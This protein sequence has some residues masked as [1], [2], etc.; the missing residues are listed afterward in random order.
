M[1]PSTEVT[2]LDRSEVV[3]WL[4]LVLLVSVVLGGVL[5]H[6]FYGLGQWREQGIHLWWTTYFS[7]LYT[8][9][10]SG[11]LILAGRWLRARVP[12]RSR[13]AVILHVGALSVVAVA[14]YGAVTGLC[15]LL[16]PSVFSVDGDTMLVTAS[17]AFL[18][19][20]L[21][22]AFAYMSRF[23]R[24]L[25]KAEAARYEAQLEAL[26]AQINPHFLFNAF[27]SIAALIRARP[28][29]AEAVVENLADLFR[30]TLWA[31][32]RNT[33]T[34]QKE[35][36]AARR[37]LAVEEA[38]FRD[39]LAVEI[40]VPETLQSASIPSMT[41]QPLVENAVK[42]GVGETNEACTVTI[43]ARR[44]D[45]TLV[46]RVTDTGPGFETDALEDVLGDGT[47]LA[48]VRDRLHVFY[49]EDARMHLLPQ[50]VELRLP[51]QPD[52]EGT[53][54]AASTRAPME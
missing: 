47:G 49:G 5:F 10:M 6:L 3:R 46:L 16:H 50:G 45:D 52:A 37:Y 48:N 13:Q 25:R 20:L 7:F 38:R 18:V 26:R 28:D 34:L 4:L 33:S 36:D 15:V 42:H 31:S 51:R 53:P 44:E 29:E 8:A 24:Q 17:L 54:A 22:S 23:Y 12:V 2:A 35:V 27:N 39:R 43:A 14:S 9:V 40:D 32:K 21:W 41:L 30:Y 1:L 19:T 11:S